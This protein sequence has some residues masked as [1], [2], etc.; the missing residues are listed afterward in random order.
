ME[1][2]D[3]DFDTLSLEKCC[4]SYFFTTMT[5]RNYWKYFIYKSLGSQLGE[6]RRIQWNFS[7]SDIYKLKK[8]RFVLQ[9]RLRGS[10]PSGELIQHHSHHLPIQKVP[11]SGQHVGTAYIDLKGRIVPVIKH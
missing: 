11:S 8:W 5:W 3:L 6:D 1:K 10:W 9:G 2:P 7:I 4:K